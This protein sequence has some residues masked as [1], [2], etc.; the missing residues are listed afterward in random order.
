[1]TVRLDDSNKALMAN[2]AQ[3]QE[4]AAG[5][6]KELTVTLVTFKAELNTTMGA[7]SGESLKARETLADI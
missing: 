4:D 7:L 1:M 6:R 3:A 2:L 5:T